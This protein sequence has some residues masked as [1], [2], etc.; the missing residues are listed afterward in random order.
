VLHLLAGREAILARTRR[1]TAQP[2]L[3][4]PTRQGAVGHLQIVLRGNELLHPRDVAAGARKG[5]LELPQQVRLAGRRR[6]GVG[7]TQDAPHRIA[8]QLERTADL[9]QGPALGFEQADTVADLDRD[10]GRHTV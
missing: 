1:R 4:D 3:P 10:H 7:L 6:R 9:A 2:C 5:I 8:R